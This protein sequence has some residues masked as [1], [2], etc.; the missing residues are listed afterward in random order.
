MAREKQIPGRFTR[1]KN[2]QPYDSIIFGSIIA[3]LLIIYGSLDFIVNLTNTATLGTMFLVNVSAFRL[4]QRG[5]LI[6]SDKSYFKIPF[7]TLFPALGAISCILMIL[8]LPPTTIV[9]GLA[10]MFLGS[11][12]YVL[13][14]K[15]IKR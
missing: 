1:V 6:P 4:V 8:T 3:T 9:M 10:A 13:K 2:G 7:G 12:F 11:V 14:D 15:S 5:R